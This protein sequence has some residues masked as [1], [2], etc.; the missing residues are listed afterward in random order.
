MSSLRHNPLSNEH[1][2]AKRPVKILDPDEI[3]GRLAQV[4]WCCNIA[5]SNLLVIKYF[6]LDEHLEEA[7]RLFYTPE[8]SPERVPCPKLTAQLIWAAS[9]EGRP[10]MRVLQG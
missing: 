3:A 2:T 5:R 7:Q 1:F 8:D 10:L 9:D 4:D 6:S